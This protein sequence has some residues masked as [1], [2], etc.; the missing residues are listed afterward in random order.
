MMRGSL[1]ATTVFDAH[2]AAEAGHLKEWVI[3]FLERNGQEPD[4][5]RA[6]R[7]P[8]PRMI[9]GPHY[10]PLD[11]FE[12]VV[13]PEPGMAF[14]EDKATFELRVLAAQSKIRRGKMPAPILVGRGRGRRAILCDG[15]HTLEALRREGFSDY[16]SIEWR[17][18]G[19][20]RPKHWLDR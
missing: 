3:G 4:L 7:Q 20:Y 15:N 1:D 17:A 16:W 19:D 12:R 13:G 11:E 2:R 8:V 14:P 9:S 6:L 10:V 18:W 5:V